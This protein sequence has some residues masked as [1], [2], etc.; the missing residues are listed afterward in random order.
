MGAPALPVPEHAWGRLSFLL[1]PAH[2]RMLQAGG[3]GKTRAGVVSCSL[4]D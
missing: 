4:F 2:S 1:L 3:K